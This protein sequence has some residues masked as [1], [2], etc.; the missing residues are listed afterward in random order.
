MADLAYFTAGRLP[1]EL[2]IHLP[3][4][5]LKETQVVERVCLQLPDHLAIARL[6]VEVSSSEIG[7]NPELARRVAK[8]LENYNVGISI[9]DVIADVS[10]AE[11]AD[12]PIAA[13]N[14]DRSFI[15][16][17]ADDRHKRS[18]CG[19]VVRIASRLN[20]RTVAKG[21]ETTADFQAV[22]D[23]GF[24]LGQGDLFA[25]LMDAG[26]FARTLLPRRD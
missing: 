1:I 23:M 6:L 16:G 22:C 17:C 5:A 2:T 19:T 9:D 3:M 20:A 15:K 8:N 26:K 14:V 11:M 18:A 13:L 12:F 10:W 25:K 4:V 7:Q 21:I 24:D